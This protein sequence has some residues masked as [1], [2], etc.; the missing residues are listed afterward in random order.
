MT[1]INYAYKMYGFM[2]LAAT[3]RIRPLEMTEIKSMN[4]MLSKIAEVPHQTH[5]ETIRR[6]RGYDINIYGMVVDRKQE[7]VEQNDFD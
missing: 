5:R 7:L 2:S 4:F 1:E 3:R 6:T